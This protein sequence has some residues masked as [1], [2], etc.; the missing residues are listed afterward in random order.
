MGSLQAMACG[1]PMPQ[2][3]R[4]VPLCIVAVGDLVVASFLLE[5]FSELLAYH[6]I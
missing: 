4:L 1:G 3:R 6:N 2:S 5:V